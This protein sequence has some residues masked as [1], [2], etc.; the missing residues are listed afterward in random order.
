MTFLRRLNEQSSSKISRGASPPVVIPASPTPALPPLP[1]GSF[2]GPR[3]L[4][5]NYQSRVIAARPS[6]TPTN[7][8]A[9]HNSSNP[10]IVRPRAA[11][12]APIASLAGRHLRG[13]SSSLRVNSVASLLRGAAGGASIPGTPGEAKGRVWREE[14]AAPIEMKQLENYHT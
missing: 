2:K 10:V 14:I 12:Q 9:I 13:G 8:P 3:K 7:T 6:R 11:S 5:K 1:R 4:R